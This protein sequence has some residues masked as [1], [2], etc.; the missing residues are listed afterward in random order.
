[1]FS[2]S[3]ILWPRDTLASAGTCQTCTRGGGWGE[4]LETPQR[5]RFGSEWEQ[6]LCVAVHGGRDLDGPWAGRPLG[7]G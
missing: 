5:E 7:P 3:L 1:M 4:N 6:C 2:V